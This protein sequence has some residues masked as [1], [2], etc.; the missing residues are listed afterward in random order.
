MLNIIKKIMP[1]FILGGVTLVVLFAWFQVI[2]IKQT[3]NNFKTFRPLPAFISCFFLIITFFL[4]SLSLKILLGSFKKVP[5][6]K[7]FQIYMAGAFLNSFTSVSQVGLAVEIFLLKKILNIPFSKSISAF[8]IMRLIELTATFLPLIF[9]PFTDFRVHYLIK[10]WLS[11]GVCL[12]IMIIILLFLLVRTKEKGEKIFGKL[13]FF[14][15]SFMREKIQ[16][17]FYSILEGGETI[18][19]NK[20]NI[21][22]IVIVFLL[23]PLVNLTA[24][25][26]MFLS[27]S[28]SFSSPFF[29]KPLLSIILSVM[30]GQSILALLLAL[31]ALPAQIGTLEW[32]VTLIFS[33]GFDFPKEIISTMAISTHILYTLTTFFTGAVC[34]FLLGINLSTLKQELIKA[35]EE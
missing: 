17:F 26:F 35:K 11:V 8:I 24:G 27:F 18:S 1:F 7:V 12:F 6:S 23:I 10:K 22:F 20:V 16:K 34:T 31:P 4:Q 9:I 13:L 3:I 32:Y 5:L 21:I 25:G 15:P 30:I 2:D 33:Y 29:S 28:F 14:I 19:K